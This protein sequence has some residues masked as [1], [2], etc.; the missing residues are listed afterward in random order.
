MSPD[1]ALPFPRGGTMSDFGQVTPT[2]TMY[3]HIEG[4][5]Y[6]VPDTVHG[7]GEVV[8]LRAVKNDSGADI[9]S[10]RVFTGLS[11]PSDYDF[12]RRCSGVVGSAGAVCKPMDDKYP[13]GT[14]IP[15]DDIFWVVEAGPC[16]VLTEVTAVNLAAG[17]AVASDAS[18]FINGVTCAQATEF[19][20][21]NINA[22]TVATATETV[23]QV[24][25]GLK[26][27]G[28]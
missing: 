14:V 25:K 9:T 16:G 4:R 28:T 1:N 27:I 19:C 7:T 6:R 2:D 18:G 15:D 20:V 10:A 21:G 8:Y 22:A 26:Q 3:S 11:T 17:G 24:E 12:G 5:I 23:V 13:V